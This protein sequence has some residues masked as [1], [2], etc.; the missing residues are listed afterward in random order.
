MQLHAR[1]SAIN[2]RKLFNFG[3]CLIWEKLGLMFQ[4]SDIPDKW[5]AWFIT[6]CFN[7]SSQ[8]VPEHNN[9]KCLVSIWQN[10]FSPMFVSFIDQFDKE[11]H[12][13]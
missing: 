7:T 2:E 4:I 6:K 1:L 12:C 3:K 9:T 11:A 13:Y 10:F 5:D 8:S